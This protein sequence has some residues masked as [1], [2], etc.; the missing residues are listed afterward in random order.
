[1]LG[2]G[3]VLEVNTKGDTDLDQSLYEMKGV[4]LFVKGLE[5]ELLAGRADLAVHS[6]KDVP[7]TQPAGLVIAAVP[8]IDQPRGDVLL[9]RPGLHLASISDLPDGAVVGT[10]S[11]RRAAYLREKLPLKQLVFTNI[12]GNLATRLRK[13][14]EGEYDCIVL[15]AA[16]VHRLGWQDKVALYL[17]EAEFLYAPGQAALGV[18]CRSDDIRTLSLLEAVNDCDSRLRVEAERHFMKTLEGVS[19]ISGLQS[20]YRRVF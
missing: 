17:E 14:E 10:S 4:G 19:A 2:G 6:L 18:E 7:T 5:V 3:T 13:L 16:G 12:R 1:M 9:T 11:L 20:P 15:A 8:R